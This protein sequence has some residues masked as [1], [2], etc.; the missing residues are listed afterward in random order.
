M[1]KKFSAIIILAMLFALSFSSCSKDDEFKPET[2]IWY[3]AKNTQNGNNI[4]TGTFCFFKNGDYD[5]ASF[6]YKGDVSSGWDGASI[7]TQNGETVKS[8]FVDVVTKDNP[9]YGTHECAPGTYYMVV[10]VSNKDVEKI[11]K[12]HKVYVEKNKITIIEAI[13]KDMYTSGY[14][15]WDE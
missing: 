5:P 8:F 4:I 15:E 6:K 13:F 14:I 1:K 11:W 3:I 12:T 7:K 2:S 9:G 10:L